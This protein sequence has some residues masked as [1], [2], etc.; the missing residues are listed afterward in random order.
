M[1]R[2]TT[3][4]LNRHQDRQ[5]H[6][7]A[8]TQIKKRAV[9]QIHKRTD[10]QIG[11]STDN[12][13]PNRQLHKYSVRQINRRPFRHVRRRTDRPTSSPRQMPILKNRHPDRQVHRQSDRHPA[14]QTHE[15]TDKTTSRQSDMYPDAK[16]DRWADRYSKAVAGHRQR[17][18]GC[19]IAATDTGS[20]YG[21]LYYPTGSA[22]ASSSTANSSVSGE[23]IPYHSNNTGTLRSLQPAHYLPAVSAP[24][25]P[26]ELDCFPWYNNIIISWIDHC[27]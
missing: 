24:S 1:H 12:L 8:V 14:R 26:D 15:Q 27:C 10:T 4:H 22:G 18:T 21:V 19:T 25:A 3:L 5:V 20:I 6:K 2:Q 16:T 23:S 7:R 13:R 11:K 17:D 9:G